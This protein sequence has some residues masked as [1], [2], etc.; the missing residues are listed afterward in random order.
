MNLER[1]EELAYMVIAITGFIHLYAAPVFNILS[2]NG[3]LTV[4]LQFVVIMII[5]VALSLVGSIL[6]VIKRRGFSLLAK[7]GIYDSGRY[8]DREI[9]CSACGARIHSRASACPACGYKIRG[10]PMETAAMLLIVIGFIVAYLALVKD[11]L[12]G[13]PTLK[14]DAVQ[15]MVIF[16][17]SAMIIVGVVVY[18]FR[19]A[20][21]P[22]TIS[23]SSVSIDSGDGKSGVFS[24]SDEASSGT[25]TPEELK[26]REEE[27]RDEVRRQVELES[28]VALIEMRKQMEMEKEMEA[29]RL[30]ERLEMEDKKLERMR[31]MFQEMQS[32][33]AAEGGR[34]HEDSGEEQHLHDG[35]TQ[36]GRDKMTMVGGGSVQTSQKTKTSR[37]LYPFVAI[38]GQDA[39]KR[40]LLLNAVNPEIGG[41]L[42]RGQKGTGKSVGVRGLAE[43]LPDIEVVEGC[44]FNCDPKDPAKY[45]F[46]CAEKYKENKINIIK[47]QT[48]VVDL[49]LNVTEDRI[50]GS[51][52]LEKVLTEG[53]R[54]FEPGIMAEAHRGILYV[55]EINLLDDY[56]VDVLLD[57][58]AMGINTVEREGVSVSHPARFIIVGS[59]NPEEGELRPQLLDRIAL[60]VEVKGLTNPDERIEIISRANRFMENP[61]K[62]RE[63]YFDEQRKVR[64]R[65]ARARELLP[66][67]T[68]PPK[69]MKIIARICLDFNVD[70]HRADIIIEKTARTNAAFENRTATTLEDVAYAAELALP[71][72][73]RKKPFEEEVFSIDMLRQLL[74]KYDSTID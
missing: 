8:D 38:V 66:K 22:V 43:I 4:T 68:T 10:S 55:D 59:M 60:Q 3:V 33:M 7:F 26:K 12:A 44:R 56:V 37:L 31:Q 20:S 21:Y 9:E 58:A 13:S 73:M 11:L 14:I 63:Q 32:K 5:A 65:I 72:R 6:Y 15:Q 34:K 61:Q 74:K 50:V 71:H 53:V 45:C 24:G 16:A 23:T 41:V 27:I 62:F 39:M 57:S 25:L 67:V 69:I 42:I 17:A 29:E 28:R 19:S 70:G 36:K 47:R 51:I 46:D 40:A 54:A 1:K 64:D 52:D 35:G 18:V 49:P 2:G 48:R 30:K